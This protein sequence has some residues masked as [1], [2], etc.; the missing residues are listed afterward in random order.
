MSETHQPSRVGVTKATFV[1]VT[2]GDIFILPKTFEWHSP[3]TGDVT[4][5][6]GPDTLWYVTGTSRY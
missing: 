2:V 5:Q 1:T 4:A 3:L 6:Q